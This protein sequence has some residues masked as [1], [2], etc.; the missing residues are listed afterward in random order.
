MIVYDRVCSC[1]WQF[2]D[3]AYFMLKN[4]WDPHQTEQTKVTAGL[5][6]AN[7]SRLLQAMKSHTTVTTDRV[8]HAFQ[9]FFNTL[10][11]IT[12][13]NTNFDSRLDML[14]HLHTPQTVAPSAIPPILSQAKTISMGESD[15]KADSIVG[16]AMAMPPAKLLEN[17]L[18]IPLPVPDRN[19]GEFEFS[20]A[21][22]SGRSNPDKFV[23]PS[24]SAHV[25]V[26]RRALSD[27]D[28]MYAAAVV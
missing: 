14:C 19:V 17:T 12:T 15:C 16:N 27:T 10:Q 5:V 8:E 20:R 22:L 25:H 2:D 21:T 1:A 7:Q 13:G 6:R 28:V 24:Q 26:P 23:R 3:L 9:F 11:F 4:Y 18:C